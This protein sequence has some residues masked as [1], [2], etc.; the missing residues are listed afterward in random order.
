MLILPFDT[1][2]IRSP[3]T[4]PDAAARL[5]SA[6][7]KDSL[8]RHGGPEREFAGTVGD[9]RFRV[10]RIIHYQ[11]SF[12]PRIRGRIEPAP[13]GSRIRGTMMLHPLVIAFL[14][15]W[16]G[17]VVW[18]TGDDLGALF[19]GGRLRVESVFGLGMLFFAWAITYGGFTWEALKARKILDGIFQPATATRAADP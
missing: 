3:L 19:R 7:A 2:D 14:L 5:A 15:L 6:V 11:N 1:F 16:C 10:Q 18:I 17:V 4:A 12:L 13:G 8:R 9:G